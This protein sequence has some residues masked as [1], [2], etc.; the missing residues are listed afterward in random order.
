MKSCFISC[1]VLLLASL[2]G[3]AGTPAIIPQPQKIETFDGSFTLLP[4]TQITADAG[5]QTTGNFLAA[6]LAAATGYPLKDSSNSSANGIWLT[7][8]PANAR[9]GA[10]G[11]ELVVATNSVV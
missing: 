4:T 8:H 10:E 3:I 5:S 6:R 11:Y 1:A 7:T 2:P 9:L